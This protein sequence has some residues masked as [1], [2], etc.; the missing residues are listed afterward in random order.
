MAPV[1]VIRKTLKEVVYDAH[2]VTGLRAVHKTSRSRTTFIFNIFGWIRLAQDGFE[3][4]ALVDTVV[5][6]RVF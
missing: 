4:R 1:K 5:I 6:F 3:W 2:P